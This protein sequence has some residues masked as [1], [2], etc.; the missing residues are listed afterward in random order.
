MRSAQ[1]SAALRSESLA[2]VRL[3]LQSGADAEEAQAEATKLRSHVAK[4]E[5][6]N[7]EMV[8]AMAHSEQLAAGPGH[9]ATAQ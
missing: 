1:Q 5:A 9:V 2:K 6:R 4:L 8:A 7:R 3:Q